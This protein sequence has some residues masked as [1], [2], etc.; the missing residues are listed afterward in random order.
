[1]PK[2]LILVCAAVPQ[3]SYSYFPWLCSPAVRNWPRSIGLLLSI[4]RFS[5]C[6]MTSDPRT[7]LHICIKICPN[8]PGG[9]GEGPDS[10]ASVG[11]RSGLRRLHGVLVG[12]SG[13]SLRPGVSHRA[14]RTRMCGGLERR[15]F[16][17]PV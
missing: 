8:K 6:K 13:A 3:V 1:M 4:L 15:A 10:R 7:L 12:P 9:P 11:E 2:R 14:R 17:H 5:P 16:L